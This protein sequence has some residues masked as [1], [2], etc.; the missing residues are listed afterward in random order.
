MSEQNV[1]QATTTIITPT[2]VARD[3]WNECVRGEIA[4]LESL[5]KKGPYCLIESGESRVVDGWH[6][7][8]LAMQA[9]ISG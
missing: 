6:R 1:E 3:M 4:A 5:L 9:V 7:A 8:R 2:M